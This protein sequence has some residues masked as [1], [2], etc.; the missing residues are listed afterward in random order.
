M[1]YRLGGLESPAVPYR[2]APTLPNRYSRATPV[3]SPREDIDLNVDENSIS[4][5]SAT[6]RHCSDRGRKRR[7]RVT[8]IY[9]AY[10]THTDTIVHYCARRNW[11]NWQRLSTSSSDNV[12]IL[13]IFFFFSRRKRQANTERRLKT[14]RIA[15]LTVRDYCPAKEKKNDNKKK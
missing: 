12:P 14:G 8:I 1:D 6:T 10:G 15:F 5:R 9:Y 3:D 4:S 2:R 13:F 11:Q 7:V